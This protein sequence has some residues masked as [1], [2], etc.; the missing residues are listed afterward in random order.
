M[1]TLGRAGA[2]AQDA[3]ARKAKDLALERNFVKGVDGRFTAR[4]FDVLFNGRVVKVPTIL[5]ERMRALRMDE[6]EVEFETDISLP[7]DSNGTCKDLQVGLK[8][9]LLR[10]SSHAKIRAKFSTEG[11]TEGSHVMREKLNKVLRDAFAD[12]VITPVEEDSEDVR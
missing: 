11:Q 1:A 8:R 9:G 5:L 6:F 3:S 2:E 7:D 4:T 10:R 12:A